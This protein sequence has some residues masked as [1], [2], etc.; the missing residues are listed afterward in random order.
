MI[1]G[2]LPAN[3]GIVFRSESIAYLPQTPW[4]FPGSIKENVL[5]GLPFDQARYKKV[6]EVTTLNSDCKR[7]VRGDATL[8][9]ERG[10]SLSGG[11]KA[12]I[13]LARVAYSSAKI[14][15]LDSPLVAV[16]ARI[17]GRIFERCIKQ[18]LSDRLRVLI[19]HKRHLLSEM[20]GVIIVKDNTCRFLEVAEINDETDDIL[21]DS[22]V[23]E[24]SVA[25]ASDECDTDLKEETEGTQKDIL[26]SFSSASYEEK[27]A[28]LESAELQSPDAL[29]ARNEGVVRW[30]DYLVW[31]K[32][33]YG[34]FGILAVC[35]LFILT[36]LLHAT[37]DIW[38][39]K[40]TTVA[41]R[42]YRLDVLLKASPQNTSAID[43]AHK[44]LSS[45]KWFP[46]DKNSFITLSVLTALL[47]LV[48]ISR[49]T[50]FFFA[51]QK[52]H[53]M[54][55]K[56]VMQ[57][58]MLFFETNDSGRILNRFSKD[59]NQIDCQIQLTYHD[60][61]QSS[62]LVIQ[63]CVLAVIT[64]YYVLIPLIPLVLAFV[65]G[66]TYYLA[67]SRELRR[68][69]CVAKSYILK[70]VNVSLQGLP[71]LR[72]SKDSL[73]RA[74]QE[75]HSHLNKHNATKYLMFASQRWIAIRLDS[76]SV[77]FN[78]AVILISIA[79]GIL[80]TI[81]SGDLGLVLNLCAGL[82]GMFQWCTRQSAEI[83]NLMVSVERSLE[84]TKLTPEKEDAAKID[85]QLLS[86]VIDTSD[87]RED[88]PLLT[89]AEDCHSNINHNQIS[90]WKPRAGLIEFKNVSIRYQEFGHLALRK[91]SFKIQP[92]EKIGIV[93]R[94]GAGKSSLI[95]ALFRLVELDQGQI[96]I[97][98]TDTR[99]LT[100]DTLRCNISII[101]QD[102]IMFTGTLRM[103][104]DP[105]QQSSDNEIW[106][107]L[108][109]VKLHELIN[110]SPLGLNCLVSHEGSNFST[111]QRQL[112]SLAR[113]ILRGNK[114]LII[115]EATANVD[116]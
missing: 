53:K 29:E 95:T 71:C 112:I 107:A 43:L 59:L 97:D 55:L 76:L 20:D 17:S 81:P 27:Q 82:V 72:V 52:I 9:G 33:G 66:R 42:E 22:N 86:V 73:Q 87:E 89:G 49:T 13:G 64:S 3:K 105:N 30:R 103:N 70:H 50:L 99:S 77:L 75:M 85:D 15:L 2:E 109:A 108:K 92:G 68:F 93:G 69:D 63:T 56:A 26:R 65:Y 45:Y 7:L 6:L 37:C 58:R 60:F 116:P 104:L 84:Y 21:G 23:I 47:I 19:T 101:P 62:M 24:T 83:E 111:G 106:Y 115:D 38:V 98:E 1:L 74:V 88:V 44:S 79:L 67:V 40:W 16:D 90:Q 11:Q 96:K 57:T 34:L 31:A 4:I 32:M 114:I 48:A 100:L 61:I 8:V 110:S 36:I 5:A 94:T 14:L 41:D 102:P 80:S 91:V 28:I 113:A 51:S 18:F 12:R 10:I 25:D 35:F 54:M 46:N 39:A 78:I